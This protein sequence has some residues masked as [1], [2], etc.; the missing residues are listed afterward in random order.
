M[1]GYWIRSSQ[2]RRN[3]GD[4]EEQW[5]DL[6]KRRRTERNEIFKVDGLSDFMRAEG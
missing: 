1:I 2:H 3:H 5:D 6:R 4:H